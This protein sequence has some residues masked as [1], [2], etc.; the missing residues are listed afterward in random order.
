MID[1]EHLTHFYGDRLALDDVS[2]RIEGQLSVGLLGLNGAGKSTLLRILAGLLRPSRGRIAVGD[3]DL[4]AAPEIIRRRIGYLPDEPPVYREMRVGEFVAWCG[5]LRGRTRAQV[6]SELSEVLELC[7]LKDVTNRVIESLSFG[8]RKRVGIAQA[9]IH[10]PD[11][12]LLDEPV[13]GL[14]P[15]QIV[16]MREIIRNLKRRSTVLISSH[17]LSEVTQTCD[18]VLVLHRGRLIYQGDELELERVRTGGD[19]V[20]L[21]ILSAATGA[22]EAIKRAKEVLSASFAD[23]EVDVHPASGAGT[24]TEGAVQAGLRRGVEGGPAGVV[25]ERVELTVRGVGTRRPELVR[26][27]VTAG[28]L[29]HTVRDA[30]TDLEKLFLRLTGAQS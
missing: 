26:E 3:K 29:V 1:V 30:T 13:G 2:L 20:H 14:D 7:Q 21:T 12:V 16:E 24:G 25:D 22:D 4:E 8:Y 11:L 23:A 5:E 9:I 10:R 6:R 27:L 28:V 18:R 15:V 17:I 19:A